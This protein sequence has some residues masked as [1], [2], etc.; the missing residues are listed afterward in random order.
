MKKR[1]NITYGILALVALLAAI[2]VFSVLSLLSAK[3]EAIKLALRTAPV[4]ALPSKLD[5][6]ADRFIKTGVLIL[7]P[8]YLLHP[9]RI[10][11]SSTLNMR[12]APRVTT[13]RKDGWVGK[14][15]GHWYVKIY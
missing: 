15:Q 1:L 7:E 5:D 10:E 3:E 9:D 8:A 6:G 2:R 13:D 12:L 11:D 14:Y 4:G